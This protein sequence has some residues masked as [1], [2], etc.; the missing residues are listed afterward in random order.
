MNEAERKRIVKTFITG[1]YRDNSN[2]VTEETVRMVEEMLEKLT[3]YEFGVYLNPQYFDESE[4]EFIKDI[5]DYS[6]NLVM[7]TDEESKKTIGYSIHC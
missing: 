1:Y 7:R 6:M 5:S 4:S 3:V 2:E